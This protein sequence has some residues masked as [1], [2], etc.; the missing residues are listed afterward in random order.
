MK[1]SGLGE[2]GVEWAYFKLFG[3][4]FAVMDGGQTF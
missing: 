2:T 1:G 4:F 3:T